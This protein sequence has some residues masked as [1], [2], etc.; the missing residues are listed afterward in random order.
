MQDT[1]I[2][3]KLTRL[4]EELDFLNHRSDKSGLVRR[5][6][7]TSEIDHARLMQKLV[8]N[9]PSR[10][11]IDDRSSSYDAGAP[12]ALLLS[13]LRNQ[14]VLY[15]VVEF[16]STLLNQVKEKKLRDSGNGWQT[17]TKRWCIW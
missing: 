3:E 2:D 16:L 4:E 14:R 11:S 15:S 9:I 1:D 7:D 6:Y 8:S 12:K 5:F 13:S 10:A 17:W